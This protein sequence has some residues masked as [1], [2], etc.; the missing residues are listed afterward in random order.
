MNNEENT[1]AA[2]AESAISNLP[3]LPGAIEQDIRERLVAEAESEL[4]PEDI[5]PSMSLRDD[6]GMDSMQAVSLS[7]DLEDSL[8]IT[9]DDDE[10]SSLVTVGDLFEIVQRK[11]PKE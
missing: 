7:L 4:A 8:S 9:L 1:T 3:S 11:L 10:L 2:K 6:L 5:E